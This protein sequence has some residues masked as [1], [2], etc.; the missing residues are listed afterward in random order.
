MILFRFIDLSDDG[1]ESIFARYGVENEEP[2]EPGEARRGVAR[3]LPPFSHPCDVHDVL[4][5]LGIAPWPSF[6]WRMIDGRMVSEPAPS[7]IAPDGFCRC[8]C[9]WAG[10]YPA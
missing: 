6:V 7:E 3:D 9:G 1:A 10:S 2:P 8:G 4:F 5:A